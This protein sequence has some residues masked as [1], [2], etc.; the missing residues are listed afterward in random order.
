[1]LVD[2]EFIY[3]YG[4]AIFSSFFIGIAIGVGVTLLGFSCGRKSKGE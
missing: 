1:M 2:L 3:N 4:W